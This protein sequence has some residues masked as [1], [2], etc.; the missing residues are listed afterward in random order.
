[1]L[2]NELVEVSR[3]VGETSSRTAKINLLSAA[4]RQMHSDEVAVGVAFLSGDIRQR[5]IG[6]GY[7]AIRDAQPES[8]ASHPTL[9]ILDVDAALQRIADVAPGAG[10][11][12]ERLRLLRELLSRATTDEQS[13]IAHLV[14]GELRQGALEGIMLD[15]VA[16][17]ADIPATEIRRAHMLSGSL[18]GVAAAALIG[19]RSAL[20]A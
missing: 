3:R 16:R 17:A 14:F 2:L 8:S 5:K 10:S 19:G 12:R 9:Q 20:S 13:F 11:N 15:A 7:A 18:P 6:I 4:L 1:M